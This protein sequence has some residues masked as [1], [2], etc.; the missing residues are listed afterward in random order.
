MESGVFSQAPISDATIARQMGP[1]VNV[2]TVVAPGIAVSIPV[3]APMPVTAIVP[4][5][6]LLV[7]M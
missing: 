1:I 4:P 2:P 5:S 6:V 7:V 3:L